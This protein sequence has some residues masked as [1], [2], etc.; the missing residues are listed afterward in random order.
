MGR[1]QQ[2][3]APAAQ[4][5]LTALAPCASCWL[6]TSLRSACLICTP[7]KKLTESRKTSVRCSS[8]NTWLWLWLYGYGYG[9]G[10][11]LGLHRSPTSL[12]L[13]YGYI[14][15]TRP[16][17]PVPA[18]HQSTYEGSFGPVCVCVCVKTQ[19][20]TLTGPDHCQDTTANGRSRSGVDPQGI[21][22]PRGSMQ[23]GCCLVVVLR[24]WPQK[25]GPFFN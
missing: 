15:Y 2:S 13:V 17:S 14:I 11:K 12:P 6:R 8:Y 10:F 22:Q 24:L 1:R 16:Y 25:L 9:Y 21:S 4:G 3:R 5:P 23:D 20:R 7:A 19:Q 18:S